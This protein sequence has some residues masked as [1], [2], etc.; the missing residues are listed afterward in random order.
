MPV[1]CLVLCVKL[2]VSCRKQ[3]YFIIDVFVTNIFIFSLYITIKLIT[4]NLFMY[5]IIL[6]E[7]SRYAKN[8]REE[9]MFLYDE[10]N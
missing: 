1:V 9:N 7:C 8:G 10:R 2:M 3:N 4:Y 5:L 6:R